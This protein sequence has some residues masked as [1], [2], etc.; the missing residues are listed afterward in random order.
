MERAF[1]L[2]YIAVDSRSPYF[3]VGSGMKMTN[4]RFNQLIGETSEAGRELQFVLALNSQTK[5]EEA[6]LVY[7]ILEK[8][9]TDEKKVIFLV[10]L[11]TYFKI[12]IERIREQER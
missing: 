10:R 5:T 11:I 12:R 8:M 7:N 9:D 3:N 2:Y 6:S 1:A 4:E